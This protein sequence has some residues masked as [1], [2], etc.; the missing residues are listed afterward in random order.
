MTSIGSVATAPQRIYRSR[1]QAQR[2]ANILEVTRKALAERGYDGVTM[3]ALAAEAG[4]TKR[5]L[6]N[7][8]GGKDGLLHAA[9]GEVI[10]RYRNT[11]GNIEP[12]IPAIIESRKTAVEEVIATPAYSDAMTRALVQTPADHPLTEALLRDSIEYTTRHLATA[13]QQGELQSSLAVGRIAQQIVSQG[14]GMV[15]LR[16]KGLIS[17]HEFRN[18]SL[19]GLL[20]LLLGVTSG[21]RREALAVTLEDITQHSIGRTGT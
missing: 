3:N 5:T 2:D 20:L 10:A 18:A 6:Y 1:K 21:H 4:V 8:Y 14:W 19:E 15:V 16:M 9:V 17:S 7:L 12:G 13:Q 11:E